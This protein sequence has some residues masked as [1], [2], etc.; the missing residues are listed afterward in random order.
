LTAGLTA[1]QNL[2]II[3]GGVFMLVIIAM[4]VALMKSLR[5]EPYESTLPS[6]VRRAVQY[7]QRQN[8]E[9]QHAIALTALGAEH[10]EIVPG[11]QEGRAAR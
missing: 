5:S 1:L 2:V 7:V 9:E 10:H 8:Q 3:V 4:C 6:R 11:A